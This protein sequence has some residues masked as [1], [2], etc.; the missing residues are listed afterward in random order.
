MESKR[1][2]LYNLGL[3]TYFVGLGMDSKRGILDN[4]GLKKYF[5]EIGIVL[6]KANKLNCDPM[7]GNNWFIDIFRCVPGDLG[8]NLNYV[9]IGSKI[10]WTNK[11]RRG[12]WI[13][14]LGGAWG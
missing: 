11:V 12:F 8:P 9:G 2:I 5:V 1:C 6:K 3:Q 14:G 13:E 7:V 10:I 4:L